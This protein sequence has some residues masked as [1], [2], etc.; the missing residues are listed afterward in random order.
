MGVHG[1]FHLADGEQRNGNE[2][3]HCICNNTQWHPVSSGC[4]HVKKKIGSIAMISELLTVPAL[5]I[6][7]V[8]GRKMML[9][10]KMPL[11]FYP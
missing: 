3:M 4:C 8:Q 10:Y 1:F 2:V 5:T 11:V 9:P 6:L 7:K